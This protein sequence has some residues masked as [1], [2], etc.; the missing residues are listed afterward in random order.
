MT[1][2]T[3]ETVN[4]WLELG[5]IVWAKSVPLREMDRRLVGRLRNEGKREGGRVA[6]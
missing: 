3:D 1:Q 6:A 2:K 4:W 5:T